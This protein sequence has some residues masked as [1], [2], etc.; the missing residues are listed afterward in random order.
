MQYTEEVELWKEKYA[1]REGKAWNKAYNM[2][3]KRC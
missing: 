2:L 3:R 1:S